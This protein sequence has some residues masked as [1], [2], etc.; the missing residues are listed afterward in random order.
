M[1][2]TLV[3]IALVASLS[4]AFALDCPVKDHDPTFI[5]RVGQAIKSAKSCGEGA[6]IAEAC[7]FGASGDT[8]IAPVAER[9]CGLDFWQKLKPAERQVYNGLQAKCEAKYRDMDGTMYISAAAFCKLD[10]ARLYSTLYS[11]AE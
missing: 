11:P 10:V 8:A 4:P 9:K 3:L 6:E 7:A 1:Q 5:D 2:K